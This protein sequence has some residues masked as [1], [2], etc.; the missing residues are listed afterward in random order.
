MQ[1][2]HSSCQET[3]WSLSPSTRFNLRLINEDV[4]PLH[5]VVPNP[6]TLLSNVP[7]TTTHFS[8]LDLKDAFFTVPLHPDSYFLFSFTWED[9][10][11]DLRTTGLD[12]PA[13]GIQGFSDGPDLFGQALSRVLQKYPFKHSILLQYVDDLLSSPSLPSSQED[14]TLLLNFLGSTGYR[15]TSSKVQLCTATV[16]YLGISLTPTS[17]TLTGDF[18]HLLQDLQPCS[19]RH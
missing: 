13:S 5:P 15:V 14:T 16:T 7:S 17:K 8:V 9:S 11:T 2:P 10:N 6:Y 19:P 3:F 18:I 1:H 4:I 12:G